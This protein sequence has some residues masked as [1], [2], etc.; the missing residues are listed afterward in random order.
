MGNQMQYAGQYVG[1]QMDQIVNQ[2]VLNQNGIDC[3]ITSIQKPPSAS[4]SRNNVNAMTKVEK[5]QYLLILANKEKSGIPLTAEEN[6]FRAT[7]RVN[8]NSA[9]LNETYNFMA[10]QQATTSSS[11]SD[12]PPT[13]DSDPFHEVPN[14]G[15][16]ANPFAHEKPHYVPSEPNYDTYVGEQVNSNVNY[17]TPD[18]DPNGVQ[19]AQNGAN[20]E[21]TRALF[22]SL[23]NNCS[24]EIEKVKKVNRD[25]KA[26]NVKL[27]VELESYKKN[28]N[29]FEFHNKRLSELE[30]GYQNSVSREKLLQIKFDTL[31][32]N[33]FKKIKALNTEISE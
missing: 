17:A 25:V 1:N 5:I 16:N 7:T 23:L 13:Y 9:D 4:H 11:D 10:N 24:I 18:M 29:A 6:E 20:D 14:Y 22:E 26:A 19:V 33:S 28:V 15:N 2:N 3:F 8:D 30:T 31:D 12:L 32:V 27:T 21:E